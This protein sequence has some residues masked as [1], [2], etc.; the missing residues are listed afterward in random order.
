MKPIKKILYATDLSKPA[1]NALEYALNLATQY[2]AQLTVMHVLPDMKE[3]YLATSGLEFSAVFDDATW[4]K[5]TLE[6]L[7]DAKAKVKERILSLCAEDGV[8]SSVCLPTSENIEIVVGNPADE[9][10]ERAKDFDMVVMG[11][12]GHGRLSGFLLGS[13]AQSVASRCPVP[14]LVVRLEG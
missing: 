7:Q 4:R 14:V 13:V 8:E 12:Q 5:F 3:H 6:G 1:R 9:I 10:V 11:T 2:D